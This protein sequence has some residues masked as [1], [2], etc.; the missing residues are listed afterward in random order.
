MFEIFGPVAISIA[1]VAGF[2]FGSVWYGVLGKFWIRASNL[3]EEGTKPTPPTM[4]I[5]FV[6]Q[7]VMALAMAGVMWHMGINSIQG[8]LISAVL[9]WVGFV[10][11]TIIVNHRFQRQRWSLTFIDSGHWLGVLLTQGV[12]LCALSD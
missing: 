1:T 7:A 5:A 8:G 11:T 12:V 10:V 2:L 6:C 9:I 3:E 4:A